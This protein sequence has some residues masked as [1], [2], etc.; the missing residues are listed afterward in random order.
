MIAST[1]LGSFV[2]NLGPLANIPCGAGQVFQ[3]GGQ[4]I[5]V[6]HTRDSNV[7]ATEPTCPR[8]DCSLVDALIG[9]LK[10]ICP[11]HNLVFDLSSGRCES[12]FQSLKTYPATV[13]QE[14][15]ILIG[16]ENL[17]TRS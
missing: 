9:A 4:S 15:E 2:I 6:F 1:S 3:V 17:W 5:A 7:F 10:I 12:T 14:G 11:Q 8:D 13:N 16:I